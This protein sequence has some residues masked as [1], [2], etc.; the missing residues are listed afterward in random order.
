MLDSCKGVVFKFL[1]MKCLQ[2]KALY[3]CN[4]NEYQYKEFIQNRNLSS[5]E[6]VNHVPVQPVR[7]T[8]G[9]A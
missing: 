4:Q 2:P 9:G 1:Q 8:S 6:N 5:H 3:F 7:K